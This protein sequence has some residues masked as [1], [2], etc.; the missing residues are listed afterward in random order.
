VTGNFE[1]RNKILTTAWGEF[2]RAGIT[3]VS[4][5]HIAS[6]VGMSKKTLY[7]YFDNKEDLVRDAIQHTLLYVNRKIENILKNP[8]ADFFVRFR[9]F[10]VF[11][12]GIHSG[13]SPAFIVDLK[14]LAPNIWEHERERIGVW[15]RE[16]LDEGIAGG[17][18][19]PDVPKDIVVLMWERLLESLL[20]A[21]EQFPLSRKQALNAIARVMM[22]GIM[23]EKARSEKVRTE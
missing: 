7:K 16:F 20:N 15:F 22:H 12:I 11:L 6:Q 5:D 3:S 4:M 14:R 9:S 2:Y 1:I 17:V 21:D 13:I 18:F 10:C 8:K 19:Q 23:T